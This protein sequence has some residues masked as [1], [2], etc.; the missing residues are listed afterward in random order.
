MADNVMHMLCALLFTLACALAAEDVNGVGLGRGLAQAETAAVADPKNFVYYWPGGNVGPFVFPKAAASSAGTN[1]AGPKNWKGYWYTM[2]VCAVTCET[3]PPPPTEYCCA[4]AGKCKIPVP[5]PLSFEE[6][7]A[8]RRSATAAAAA[9]V[10]R[11]WIPTD[12]SAGTLQLPPNAD[13]PAGRSAAN[14]ANLCTDDAMQRK[15]AAAGTPKADGQGK[16]LVFT[17]FNWPPANA[18]PGACTVNSPCGKATCSYTGSCSGNTLSNGLVLMAA[19]CIDPWDYR[20]GRLEDL[21]KAPGGYDRTVD[22]CNVKALPYTVVKVLVCYNYDNTDGVS[23]EKR[24]DARPGMTLEANGVSWHNRDLAVNP[25]Q[26]YDQAIIFLAQP[27]ALPSYYQYNYLD[28]Y[29]PAT[30]A[31]IENWS[32]IGKDCKTCDIRCELS[33]IGP[34]RFPGGTLGKGPNKV[35][36]PLTSLQGNSGSCALYAPDQCCIAVS[37]VTTAA[38]TC[39]NTCDN[40]WSPIMAEKPLSDL[41]AKRMMVLP[42]AAM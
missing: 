26:N 9:A 16:V 35:H 23:D 24:C 11:D 8:L 10:E 22:P 18:A 38:V 15:A 20:R 7:P 14:P 19:H 25:A 42:N 41:W 32:Y 4:G 21:E 17:T 1:S 31:D 29:D 33:H 34:A 28:N 5:K 40:Y 39:S 13:V 12:I 37:H 2:G 3:P 30:S 36:M 27:K 6:L